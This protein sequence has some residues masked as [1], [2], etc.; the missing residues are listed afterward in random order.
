MN[1][2]A[3]AFLQNGK[4]QIVRFISAGGF[5]CTYEAE[6][7]GLGRVAIKEFF[8]SDICNRDS[9]TGHI[10]VGVAT[11][12]EM[13]EKLRDKF[14]KEAKAVFNLSHPGIVHVSDVF[15]EN[16]TTYF[17]MDYIDGSSLDD[18]VSQYGPMSEANA[19]EFIRQVC[20][21]LAYVHANNRLHLDIKPGNVMVDQNGR[22]ILIDFGASKQYDTGTGQNLSTL[23]GFTPGYAPPEQMSVNVQNFLPA[24]DI[25]S[26]GATLYTLLTGATPTDSASRFSGVEVAVLPSTISVGTRHAVESALQLNKSARPQTVAEFSAMLFGETA[27]S[28]TPT[29]K[30]VASLSR[31]TERFESRPTER[32]IESEPMPSTDMGDG[33]ED[34]SCGKSLTTIFRIIIA[35]LIAVAIALVGAI[36]FLQR[37]S[38]DS[39]DTDALVC[40]KG[41][42]DCRHLD[43]YTIY[44]NSACFFTVEEWQ[45]VPESER[46]EYTKKGV[47]VCCDTIEAFYLALH[48]SGETMTWYEAESR[49]GESALPS[50]TQC[51][52]M[53]SKCE[54]INE[55]IIAFGGDEH[56]EY[57][58]WGKGYSDS[59]A[60]MVNMNSNYVNSGAKSTPLRVRAVGAVSRSATSS[61]KVLTK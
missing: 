7:T 46:S 44:E 12:A 37:G 35:V 50:E 22:A 27:A 42:D 48:D 49:Y 38:D 16:G 60:W 45:A 53:A 13:F 26:L 8:V 41:H 25:Y 31:A 18:L 61:R 14:R 29:P 20:D 6:Q 56:P 55:A 3:G 43:L 58:Y 24:T 52:A 10:S 36:F 57:W 1:L 28:Q 33:D 39:S 4:Y 23:L 47:V 59:Y 54:D 17:V 9:D 11:K 34:T 51:R 5:G 21:A 40:E 15:D 30:P 19:L 2:Q 32:K